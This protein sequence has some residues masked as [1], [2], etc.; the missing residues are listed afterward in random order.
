MNFGQV[1]AEQRRASGVSQHRLALAVETTQRHLSFLET[2][3]SR[4]TREMI[5][6]LSDALDLPPGR[7]AD[8]FEAAGYVSP[9]RRRAADDAAV[10]ETLLRLERYILAP[11]PYPALALTETWDVLAANTPGRKLF[12]LE[13]TV[14]GEP[15]PNLFER[16]LD[17]SFRAGIANWREV[18]AVVHARLRRHAFEH[19]EFRERLDRAVADGAFTDVMR[20]FV[21][22]EEIP[23]ILPLVFALPN[24]VS[25]RMTSM[26]A[27]LTSAHDDL[28]RGLEIEL[29]IPLDDPSEV[30]L[31]G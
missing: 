18:G 8:L 21:E 31:R 27:R 5:L 9:Y 6:R 12:G 7:R 29:C 28:V 2:G 1:L 25:F 10:V 26:S 20:P 30:I 13:R 22:R 23:V 17:P 11:W 3:R 14:P 16:M 24:G 19:A 4:P 15:L